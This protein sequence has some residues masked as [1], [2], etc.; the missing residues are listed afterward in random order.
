MLHLRRLLAF[1]GLLLA[2]RADILAEN[3]ALREV[4]EGAQSLRKAGV[5]EDSE[6][7]DVWDRCAAHVMSGK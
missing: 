1:L 3:A 4:V 5:H 2:P 6:R 7:R